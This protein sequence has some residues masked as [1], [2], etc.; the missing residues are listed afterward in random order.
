MRLFRRLCYLLLGRVG[1]LVLATSVVA[2]LDAGVD[3]ERSDCI[4]VLLFER[5]DRLVV[6]LFHQLAVL[7]LSQ[8]RSLTLQEA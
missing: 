2:F 4:D 8:T 6:N 3:P 1:K 7:L 5:R